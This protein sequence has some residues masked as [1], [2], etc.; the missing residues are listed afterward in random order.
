MVSI[1]TRWCLPRALLALWLSTL[2]AAHAQSQSQSQS[3]DTPRADPLDAK[4]PVPSLR[5]ESALASFRRL[6]SS[7]PVPWRDAN[8]LV[9]RIGGWRV[10]TREAHQPAPEAQPSHKH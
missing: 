3:A 4:A 9:T 1:Q 8:D 7:T 5:Y 10:Y 6:D 2:L